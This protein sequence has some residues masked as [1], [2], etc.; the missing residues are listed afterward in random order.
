M[1]LEDL[2][3]YTKVDPGPYIGFNGN[4]RLIIGLMVGNSDTRV[5]KDFGAGYF[6]SDFGITFRATGLTLCQNGS[7]Y[8]MAMMA[9]SIDDPVAIAAASGYYLAVMHSRTGGVSEVWVEECA[10]GAITSSSKVSLSTANPYFTWVRDFDGGTSTISCYTDSDRTALDGSEALVLS[11]EIEY[12]YYYAV[13]SYNNG[14]SEYTLVSNHGDFEITADPPP[15]APTGGM[16]RHFKRW[17][18]VGYRRR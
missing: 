15:V 12:Q 16:K 18:T 3:T 2:T 11:G 14:A 5:F 17:A 9:N 10:G 1:A 7:Q 6:W 13:S 4:N 8:V